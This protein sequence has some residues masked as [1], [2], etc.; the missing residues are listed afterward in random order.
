MDDA[1][2]GFAVLALSGNIAS[3][4]SEV[5]TPIPQSVSRR[6]PEKR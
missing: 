5:T 6:D 2:T 4:K 1:A 3:G